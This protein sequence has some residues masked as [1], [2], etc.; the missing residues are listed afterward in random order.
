MF[1]D[2]SFTV[3][4]TSAGCACC[5]PKINKYKGL[6]IYFKLAL[7]SR[8]ELKVEKTYCPVGVIHNLQDADFD[9]SNDI[10]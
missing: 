7:Q 1:L 3:T 4:S 5:N 6:N 2:I 10:H 9:G 8:K